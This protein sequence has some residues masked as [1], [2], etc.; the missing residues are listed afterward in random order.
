MIHILLWIYGISVAVSLFDTFLWA[1]LG[2]DITS[3]G[4]SGLNFVLSFIPIVNTVFAFIGL[5]SI[6]IEIIEKIQKWKSDR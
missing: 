5:V 1:V 4:P 6:P 3:K 2:G